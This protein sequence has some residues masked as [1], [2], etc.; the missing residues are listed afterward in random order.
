MPVF[1][2][3]L[4]NRSK[5][6]FWS[7]SPFLLGGAAAVT[8]PVDYRDVKHAAA[9]VLCDFVAIFLVL[10]LWPYHVIPGV[11]RMLMGTVALASAVYLTDAWFPGFV[12]EKGEPYRRLPAS[13]GFLIIGLPCLKYA[14][15]GRF[16][17]APEPIEI[18]AD[19]PLMLEA[20]KKARSSIHR[21]RSGF[22]AHPQLT[23]V[24][25][26]FTTDQPF[27]EEVEET[28]DEDTAEPLEEFIVEH[29]WGQL[30]ELTER[31]ARLE[32]VTPPYFHS[33]P[34]DELT[35]PIDEIE[36]WEVEFDDGTVDGGFTTRAM[37]AYAV[38]ESLNVPRGVV[39]RLKRYRDTVGA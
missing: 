21:L 17:L 12:S 34:I 30:V 33:E 23:M 35:V 27:D 38:R 29:L 14:A 31:E 16:R 4:F 37:H 36:D 25:V 8:F 32:V 7:L 2:E 18:A 15:L 10:S 11:R 3:T 6:F 9:V 5:F 22:A 1:G 28:G 24:R 13:L 19:E 20:Y 39:I 26:A